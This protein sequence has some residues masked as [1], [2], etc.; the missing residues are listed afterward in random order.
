MKIAVPSTKPDLSGMVE[1]KLGSAAY[2]LVIETDD[3]SFTVLDGPSKSSGPGAG[4][5]AV[6]LV[7]SMGAQAVLVGYISSGIINALKK[8]GVVVSTDVSGS[9]EEAVTSFLRSSSLES[10]QEQEKIVQSLGQGEWSEAFAKGLRQFYSLL[11]RLIGV[12][13]LL[14]LFRGFVS[15]QALLSLFS[16]SELYNSLLGAG[17]G[18]VLAGNPINSYV[19]GKSLLSS[20]VGLVGAVALMLAWVNVG[21]IQLPIETAALGLRFAVV[22]N[23]AGFFVAV[24]MAFVVVFWVGGII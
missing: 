15:E 24:I 4:V 6:S 13:L 1:Q 18:S 7:V 16:G 2:L 20:G 12:I 19:I 5:Q 10:K 3:M 21:V 8:Q 14:G 22:R 11:P 23:L 17:L 9:V